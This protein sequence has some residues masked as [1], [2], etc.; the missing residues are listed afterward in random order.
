MAEFVGNSIRE[1]IFLCP[2]A[3]MRTQLSS[4]APKWPILVI[5]ESG[6]VFQPSPPVYSF[7]SW[8]PSSDCRCLSA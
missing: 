7:H 2:M 4:W 3:N 1:N 8:A 6:S 5:P